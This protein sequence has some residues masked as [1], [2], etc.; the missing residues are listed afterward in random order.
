M[1]ILGRI[2]FWHLMVGTGFVLLLI[3]L[4]MIFLPPGVGDSE[5]FLIEFFEASIEGSEMG[6][7]LI[8]LGLSCFLIGRKDLADLRTTRGIQEELGKTSTLAARLVA[9]KVERTF[10]DL[11]A[12]P[13]RLATMPDLDLD[14][15]R[16]D[17]KTLKN[18]GNEDGSAA[19]A[20]QQAEQGLELLQALEKEGYSI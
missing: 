2:R 6:L 20:I 4:V 19:H 10:R 16:Q 12:R 3:G 1:D 15:A 13:I 18:G 7:A 14:Q 17:L 8:V 9:D 5:P 11:P